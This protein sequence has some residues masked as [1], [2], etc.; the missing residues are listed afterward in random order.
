MV[1][2]PVQGSVEVPR[3]PVAWQVLEKVVAVADGGAMRVGF[4]KTDEPRQVGR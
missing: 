3:V 4:W 1:K 2:Q